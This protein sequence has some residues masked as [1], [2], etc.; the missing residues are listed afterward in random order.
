MGKPRPYQRYTVRD[1]GKTV[2]GGITTDFE[3]RKQE[4]KQ[5]HPKSIVRKV[6]G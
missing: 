6:G 3:R 1:K 4:H 5:E 2:H